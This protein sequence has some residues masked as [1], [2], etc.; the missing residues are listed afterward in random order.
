MITDKQIWRALESVMDPEIDLSVVDLGLVYDVSVT[1]EGDVSVAMTLTTKGCPMS[2]A[3]TKSVE[4][5]V[6][7]LPGV[8]SIRVDLVWDP[9]WNPRMLS[10]EGQKKMGKEPGAVKVW[11][12]Y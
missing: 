1:A 11:E 9:P 3:L 6:S 10:L 2:Q 7:E 4:K 12:K 8:T 5:A